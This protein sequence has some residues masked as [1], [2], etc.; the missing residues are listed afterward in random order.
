[1]GAARGR[2]RGERGARRRGGAGDPRGARGAPRG[3]PSPPAAGAGRPA[4]RLYALLLAAA[5]TLVLNPRATEDVGWQLSFAAV[6][7][8]ALLAGRWRAALV[9]RRVP[10]PVA[11]ALAL[12]AAA[13]VGTAPLLALHFERLSIVSLPA[14]LAAAPAVAP[15]VW[16]GTASAVLGLSGTAGGAWTGAAAALLAELCN[17]IAAFPLGFVGWVAHAAAA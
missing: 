17:A 7:A 14:N 2:A 6:V 11:E 3:A 12:T 10:I 4:S 5:V 1:M 9:A 15:V 8:I 13:T 16:L